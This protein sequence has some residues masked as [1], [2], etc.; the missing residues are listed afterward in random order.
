[1]IEFSNRFLLAFG[2]YKFLPFRGGTKQKYFFGGNCTLFI[3]LIFICFITILALTDKRNLIDSQ[4]S[5][6]KKMMIKTDL[7]KVSN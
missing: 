5:R 2:L 7:A 3:Y 1:M 4:L 6:W